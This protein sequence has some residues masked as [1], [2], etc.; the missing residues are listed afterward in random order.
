MIS[1]PYKKYLRQM[2]RFLKNRIEIHEMVE[3]C[4]VAVDMGHV[5][6]LPHS[7]HIAISHCAAAGMINFNGRALQ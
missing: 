3:M 2:D 1:E 4:Q 6:F 5:G 7:V